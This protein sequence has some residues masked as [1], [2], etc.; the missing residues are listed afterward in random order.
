MQSSF[1]RSQQ[2]DRARDSRSSSISLRLASPVSAAE[3]ADS[4]LKLPI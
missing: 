3:A 2:P 1:K 4:E